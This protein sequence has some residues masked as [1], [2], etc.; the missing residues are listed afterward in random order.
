MPLRRL[1][2]AAGLHYKRHTMQTHAAPPPSPLLKCCAVRRPCAC[3]AGTAVVRLGCVWGCARAATLPG[4]Q[5]ILGAASCPGQAADLCL[6]AWP[7][8]S[9]LTLLLFAGRYC[10]TVCAKAH[11]KHH[12]VTC[13][14]VAA[15]AEAAAAGAGQQ[16]QRLGWRGWASAA[17]GAATAAA[18]LWTTA[19]AAGGA[20]QQ[21]QQRQA[22]EQRQQEQQQGEEEDEGGEGRRRRS[23]SAGAGGGGGAARG[24]GRAQSR[25]SELHSCRNT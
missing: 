22:Q 1:H 23:S 25:S 9:A 12:S 11:W 13:T 20:E 3:L 6:P 19:P 5:K 17:A 4:A 16:Q 14:R 18:A 24:G 21:Q 15:A 2:P 8:S 7:G 10:C